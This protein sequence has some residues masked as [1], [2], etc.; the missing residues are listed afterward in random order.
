MDFVGRLPKSNGFNSILVITDRLTNY[1][2]IEPTDTTATAPDIALLVYR[3][4][5][6]RFGLPQRIV[7]DRDKLFMSGFWKALH[8]L[9][10]IKIQASTA[11][12][13]EIDGSSERLN[14]TAIQA[15]R[16]HAWQRADPRRA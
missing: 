11:Y 1:V 7:S 3:T 2:L 9:L 10:G 6:R 14:R 16:N 8:K 4:C 5:C 12:H 13:P 15:L